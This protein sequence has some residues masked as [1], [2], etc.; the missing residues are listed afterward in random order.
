MYKSAGNIVSRTGVLYPW[1]KQLLSACKDAKSISQIH[2]LMIFTGVFSNGDSNGQLIASYARIGDVTSARRVFE[3][4][5]QRGVVTWNAMIIAYSRNDSP[6]E[7]QNLYRRMILEGVRPDS[8]TFTVTL[9][10]CSSLLDLKAGE[11]IRSQAIDFGY[12]DDIFVG[13]SILN[14]YAKCGKMDEALGIFNGMTKR[15]LVS[16]TTMITGF[17]QSGQPVEAV[18]VFRRMQIEEIKGDAVLMVGLIQACTNLGDMKL[19]ISVHGY[20]IRQHLPMDVVVET[21]LVD[22]YAKKGLLNLASR[23][24]EKMS[25]RNVVSWSALMSGFAQNGFAGNALELLIEMQSYGFKP[26]LVS[27]VS[28]LLACSQ[29]GFLKLGKSIHGYIVRRVE[30]DRVSGTA[31]IDM[32]SKCGSLS[33]ARILFD[34]I[35]Y[36]DSISWNAMIAS[37]GIHGHG[38]EALSLFLQMKLMSQRP[39]HATFASLLSAL[40]HSGLVE[41]GRYWFG[42]MHSDFGIQPS[43]KHFACMVDLLARAGLVEEAHKLIGSM[44]DEPGIAVWV[45]LLAGCRNHGKLELG[46][47]VAKKVFELKPND[48][49]IYALVSN[50][51][52]LARK[53]DEVALVRKVMKETGMKKVPGY[54]VV[55]VRGKLHAFLMEDKSHPQHHMI[56]A[57]LD[58]LE[59]EMRAMGYVPR[60]EY[61]LHDLDEQVKERMLCNHSERLAIAFG[62]LNTGPGTRLLI[63][64]NLRVCRD[65]HEATKFISK[66]VDRE[67]VVRDI[68]RFH[69]FKDGVCSCGDYW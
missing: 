1:P 27:L 28:A 24:F 10:A 43:E 68:K 57:M 36:R 39:D 53:W 29:I 9:K 31:V 47:K 21:S 38:K 67:I 2:A 48:P 16:W 45:A 64:K 59:Y 55:E 69:H 12:K 22:M 42:I 58:R 44:E 40:S 54:S 49:G 14:L 23:V 18:E 34:R 56:A 20:M 26:D 6:N 32:Y 65:C 37:Y 52:A 13:S 41:E 25:Y 35:S 61:V 60:T 33:S 19:G 51:F 66:I 17:A 11:K 46:E 50:V 7:V 4:S 62:L 3:E 5:P 63:T 8:S 30:F 15:D